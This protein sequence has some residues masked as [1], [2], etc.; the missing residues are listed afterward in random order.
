M[1]SKNEIIT[2]LIAAIVLFATVTV[3][4]L[5]GELKYQQGYQKALNKYVLPQPSQEVGLSEKRKI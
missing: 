1:F 3:L 4:V 5:V 2:G